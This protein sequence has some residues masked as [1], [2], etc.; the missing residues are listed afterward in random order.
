MPPVAFA[1]YIQRSSRLIA[2]Q[3]VEL[4]EQRVQI[5]C[6]ADFGVG[7]VAVHLIGE[8]ESSPHGVVNKN[9]GIVSVP[10]RIARQQLKLWRKTVRPHLRKEPEERAAARATLQPDHQRSGL[11]AVLRV[12]IPGAQAFVS[13]RT[14]LRQET[15]PVF[16]QT[17]GQTDSKSDQ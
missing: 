9:H 14:T 12:E 2:V 6:D 5:L 7:A 11:V 13:H 17:D 16:V 15:W 8:G 4:C 3:H 1:C 10:C